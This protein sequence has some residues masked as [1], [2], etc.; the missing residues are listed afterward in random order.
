MRIVAAI[1]IVA[2]FFVVSVLWQQDPILTILAVPIFLA[3]G[4]VVLRR[5]SPG[6]A[7][8]AGA[9]VAYGIVVSVGLSYTLVL[10]SL[11][12]LDNC[13][14]LCVTN[15]KEFVNVAILLMIVAAPIAAVGGLVSALASHTL[16]RPNHGGPRAT[17]TA[18]HGR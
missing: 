3:V 13:D 5:H 2:L 1:T 11:G 17:P 16:V 7:L 8:I 15:A 6:R 12:E 9:L 18:S 4:F 14:G 10:V